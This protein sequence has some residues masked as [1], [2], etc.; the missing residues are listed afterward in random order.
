MIC[1]LGVDIV[2]ISRIE[3]LIGRCGERFLHRIFSQEEMAYARA[4]VRPA[5]AFAGM[6]AA[7]EACAKAL[8]CGIGP[9]S[10]Q[11]MQIHRDRHGR[12]LLTL[13]PSAINRLSLLGVKLHLTISH[14]KEMA[15]AVVIQEA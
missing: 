12:P 11:D 8:G 14:E 2:S 1:G 6:F 3:G 5:T 10:W 9:I 7:K 15:V 13:S 4:K